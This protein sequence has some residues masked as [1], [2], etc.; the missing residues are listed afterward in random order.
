MSG[1]RVG[2]W[3]ESGRASDPDRDARPSRFIG[4]S[5]SRRARPHTRQLNACRRRCASA[6]WSC[7][8]EGRPLARGQAQAGAQAPAHPSGERARRPGA[9]PAA[10]AAA[11]AGTGAS[12]GVQASTARQDPLFGV[13]TDGSP[14]DGNVDA[15]DSL[16]GALNRRIDIV[17]WYQNW[18]PGSWIR[19]YHPDV[20]AAVTSSGRIAA[21]DLGAVGPGRRARP[22]A[23]PPAPDRRGRLRRLHRV[24]GRAAQD[25][26]ARTS[27]C[28]RCTR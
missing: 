20:V 2:G 11:Q 24:L 25:T 7:P 10:A 12:S 1:N 26:R 18:E 17:N 14:Y 22:A 3:G 9:R 28:A 6:S 16:Q 8:Q 27:T 5:V 19:E 4:G 23:V 15:I 21:A 13:F